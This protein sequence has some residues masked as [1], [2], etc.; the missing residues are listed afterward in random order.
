MEDKMSEFRSE[1][2]EGQEDAAAKALKRVR[3]EKP[4]TFK[5]KRNEEQAAFNTRVS[6]AVDEA[7]A[8]L[9]EAGPSMSISLQRAMEA[10]QRG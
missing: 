9:R 2:K 1:V 5:K 8:E 4:Y 7:E 10:L 3:F 6:E